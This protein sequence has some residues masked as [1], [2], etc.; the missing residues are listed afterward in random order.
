M[1][2]LSGKLIPQLLENTAERIPERVAL[3][4]NNGDGTLCT[5]T[6][7]QFRSRVEKLSSFIQKAG[8]TSGEHIAVL[9]KN[10]PDWATAYLAVQTAGCIVIPLDAAMRPQ[11][12][13]HIIRH[14]DAKAIF[15]DSK[16][17]YVLKDGDEEF[18]SNLTYFQLDNIESL[19][20]T[21]DEPLPPR[22]P[23]DDNLTAA[24]IYTSGTTGSP[25]GVVLTHK[26]IIADIIGMLPII[27]FTDKDNFLSVLP[28]HHAFECTCGFLTPIAIGCGICYARALRA[29]EILEDIAISNATIMLG[30]P[31]LFEK[32]Y[33]GILKGVKKKGAAAKTVFGTIISITKALDGIFK[34]HS[35][36]VL[37]S[38]FRQKAGF[39]NLWLMISGGAA[40]RPEVVHFFNHFGIICIQGYGLSETSP[41]LAVNPPFRNKASSVGPPVAG[42]DIRIGNRNKDE[43]GEIQAT[44]TPVFQKYYKNPEATEEAFTEDGWFKT[45]DLGFIDTEGYVTICGR[46]KNL[47]ITSGGKNVYPEEIEDILNSTQFILE[48]IVIGMKSGS[49]EEPF[50]IIVPDFDVIDAHFEGDW[51]NEKIERLL[52]QT[53]EDVNNK[54][55]SFKRIKG[56]KIQEDEFPKTSTKKI[57][58]YLFSVKEIR[59]QS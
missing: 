12:L 19:I 58:R 35:G 44:G 27:P 54:I 51:S 26:N 42:I 2:D 36:K 43:V 18:F 13:R 30:V 59:V 28:I 50:A 20:K 47:I 41:V 48:S 49:G 39:G 16:F 4:V 22:Y 15:M 53:I 1:V 56:F 5:L 32:F 17:M 38:A 46:K 8:F 21:E 57:K 7:S 10:S 52:R 11:E 40:I 31:L 14:S 45:G 9:G 3:M 25:K 24:I 23:D 6:Y 37:M 33:K 29:K 55:A 34:G